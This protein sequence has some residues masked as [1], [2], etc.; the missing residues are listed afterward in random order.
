[1]SLQNVTGNKKKK[2]HNELTQLDRQLLIYEIFYFCE[3]ISY[4]EITSRIPIGIRMIQRDVD[5]LMAAGLITVRYDKSWKAYVHVD[6]KKDTVNARIENFSAKKKQHIE[7][8][9]RIG[10]LMLELESDDVEEFNWENWWE[11]DEQPFD[12]SK[13]RSCREYYFSM[14]PNA[15]LRMMQHDFDELCRIGYPITYIRE[16]DMYEKFDL[17]NVFEVGLRNDFGVRMVDGKLVLTG[18]CERET[19]GLAML[20]EEYKSYIEEKS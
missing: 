11:D 1:M 17:E 18:E 15:T 19:D 14:F 2:L 13:Y 10:K 9:A 6:E 3:S 5:D 7:R 16:I 8:L 12:R 4:E 20:W